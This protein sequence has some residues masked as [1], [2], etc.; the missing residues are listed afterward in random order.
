MGTIIAILATVFI[1]VIFFAVASAV[2]DDA[3]TRQNN[4]LQILHNKKDFN[5]AREFANENFVLGVDND[6]RKIFV[7]VNNDKER[8]FA[9]SDLMSVQVIENNEV[10]YNKSTTRTIGGA[11]VGGALLGGAGAIVG[12]L[13]GSYKQKDSVESLK[14]RMLIRDINSPIIDLIYKSNDGA[15][16]TR[17]SF[18]YQ[19]LYSQPAE[20]LKA[21]LSIII[22]DEDR[23]NKV[24]Q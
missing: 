15:K 17:N 10:S 23:R 16:F 1:P 3:E 2:N 19:E 8:I 14:V 9:Y 7:L 4:M 18:L 5:V 6:N 24:S 12:G 20:E 13:S 11:I 22:D 21:V